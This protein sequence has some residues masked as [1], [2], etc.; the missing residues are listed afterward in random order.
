MDDRHQSPGTGN[1]D[2]GK[3]VHIRVIT[4]NQVPNSPAKCRTRMVGSLR[5][6][7]RSLGERSRTPF[8][9]PP[10]RAGE[11]KMALLSAT[12][13]GWHDICIGSPTLLRAAPRFT[14]K[15]CAEPLHSGGALLARS[16]HFSHGGRKSSDR[17]P[18][19]SLSGQRRFPWQL[20]LKTSK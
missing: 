9:N 6:R 15:A 5:L 10:K 2:A 11:G 4:S 17:L 3:R 20:P 18:L 16:D 19:T 13:S 7:G 8:D 14:R 1:D 12:F